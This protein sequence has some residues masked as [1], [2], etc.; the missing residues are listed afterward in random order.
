MT[1]DGR[2][3]MEMSMN[4]G[5]IKYTFEYNSDGLR[6]RKT[7]KTAHNIPAHIPLIL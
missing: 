2:Q 6:T 4:A 1:W 5:Q 3:L 7:V